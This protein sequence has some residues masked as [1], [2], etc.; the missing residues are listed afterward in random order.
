V[1]DAARAIADAFLAG[2]WDPASMGRR[3]KRVVADQRHWPTRLAEVVVREHPEPPR[4]RPRELAAFIAAC[5]VFAEAAADTDR[6]LRVAVWA[7]GSPTKM[8]HRRWDVPVID[9]MSA[10]GSWL[11]VD[12]D[13]L[14]WFADRRGQERTATDVRLVHHHRRWVRKADGSPRLLEAPKKELKDLQRQVLHEILDRIPAHDAAHGFR[15]GRSAATGA[16]R[17]VGAEVVIGLDLEAFFTSVRAGR[18]YGIFRQAGYP[19]PV[20]HVLTAL[21]TT[22]TPARVRSAAPVV[23]HPDQ[24]DRRRRLLL[25]L[26]EPHLAQG[27][28]TSPAI[29]NLVAF[30]LDRR[31]AGLAHQAG[32]I[33]TRYAD[34]LTLSGP[35]DLRRRAPAIVGLVRRIVTDEGFRLHEGKTR[36]TTAA[37]RQVVTGLVVNRAAQVARVDVDR[38][39][40]ALHRAAVH[41]PAAVD[42]AAQHADLRRHLEGRVVWAG[43]GNPARAERLR[44]ALERIDW[45]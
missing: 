7:A 16:A 18:V 38:L 17:H 8:V 30:R 1:D 44:I 12:L 25:A 24:V 10:L 45:G 37:Q 43:T 27:A 29:A 5:A 42:G 40:A 15:R 35:A 23:D 39:R 34:D 21:C 14:A 6:P 41:G 33:Y 4:D 13:H 20:A 28:P 9:D 2:S 22:T 32:M 36:V 19:E 31:L 11:G 26:A 3:A